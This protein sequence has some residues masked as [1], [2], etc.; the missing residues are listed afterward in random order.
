[1][2]IGHAVKGLQQLLVLALDLSM[3]RKRARASTQLEVLHND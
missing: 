2:R 3:T 1:M